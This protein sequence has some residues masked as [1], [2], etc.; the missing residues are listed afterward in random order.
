MPFALEAS[1]AF[2]LSTR[3]ATEADMPFLCALYGTTRADELAMTGWPQATKSLFVVQQFSAQHGEFAQ[4]FPDIER[5]IVER[6][7]VA[8]GRCYVDLTGP[9]CHLIDIALM[10]EARGRGYGKA[11][12]ADLMACAAALGKPVTLSVLSDNPA[13]R[14]YRRLGF[15]ST[16]A[17]AGRIRMEWEPPV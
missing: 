1:A 8:I 16:R 2:G 15:V 10:P 6:D 13:L 11:L 3:A 4:A 12:L 5:L 14:L 9:R 7:G 17:D